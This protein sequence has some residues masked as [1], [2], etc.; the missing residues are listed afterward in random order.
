LTSV[1]SD[2]LDHNTSQDARTE[3]GG[4]DLSEETSDRGSGKRWE[5]WA[6]ALAGLVAVYVF[7][8]VVWIGPLNA[9]VGDGFMSWS[10]AN[11]IAA[12][13]VFLGRHFEAY[14]RFAS[15]EIDIAVRLG[16]MR[17]I[18]ITEE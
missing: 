2:G 1:I 8:P 10:T 18:G 17:P 16:L 14:G 9:M 13:G 7:L 6:F 12:P 3:D 15:C 5:A 11:M 4:G